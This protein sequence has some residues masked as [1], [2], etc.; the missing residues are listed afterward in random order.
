M[1]ED[2]KKLQIAL[3]TLPMPKYTIIQPLNLQMTI[4][5]D[6]TV[7]AIDS[8]KAVEEFKRV[9]K[10]DQLRF[11]TAVEENIGNIITK[12]SIRKDY[13]VVMAAIEGRKVMDDS[14]ILIAKCEEGK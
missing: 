10:E 2:E 12:W 7:D 5:L 3:G 13:T 1:T 11:T 14:K 6:L 9:I 4:M 8:Q